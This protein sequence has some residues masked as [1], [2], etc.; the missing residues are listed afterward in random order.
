MKSLSRAADCLARKAYFL[1]KNQEFQ[2]PWMKEFKYYYD[3]D[4]PLSRELH[5][6]EL[7]FMGGKEDDITITLSQV[8]KDAGPL[9]PRRKLSANDTFFTEQKFLYTKGVP[10]NKK[11]GFKRARFTERQTMTP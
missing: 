2:S 9:D 1:G 6:D 8:F 5:P 4:I 11:E 7:D 10:S 3:N